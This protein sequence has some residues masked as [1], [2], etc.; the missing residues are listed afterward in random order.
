MIDSGSARNPT[1]DLQPTDRKPGEQLLREDPVIIIFGEKPEEHD[2][3][4]CEGAG[5]HQRGQPSGERLAEFAA[6]DQ[7]EQEA[8]ERQRG[9]E[10]DEV[11]HRRY[12]FRTTRSSAVAPGFLRKIATTSPSPT[13]T[14]A[15]ATTS[16]NTT[17]T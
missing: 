3:R 7:Q 15:A 17:T 4:G 12:P 2:N 5:H 16:T 9:N 11:E 8:G 13:T 14:S 6:T 1:L 10:P